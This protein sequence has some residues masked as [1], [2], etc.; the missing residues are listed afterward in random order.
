MKVRFLSPAIRELN[1]AIKYYNAQKIQLGDE[2]RDEVWET[3]RRIKEFPLAW[4][5]L[6]RRTRRCQMRRFPYGIIYE[7]S[8]FEIIIIAVAH[9]HQEPEYWQLRVQ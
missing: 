1:E 6:G 3:V 4:R 9:L 8:E 7:P 2:F 5:D